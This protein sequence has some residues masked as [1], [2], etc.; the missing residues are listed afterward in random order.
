M[1]GLIENYLASIP[2]GIDGY[3]ECMHKGEPLGVWLAGSPLAGLSERVPAPVAELLREPTNLP[4]W[5][6]EVHATVIY[7]AMREVHFVTDAAFLQHAENVNRGVLET[8]LNRFLFWVASPRAILRGG[9][10]RWGSLHK[11]STIEIRKLLEDSARLTLRFPPNLLPE[12]IALG[13]GTGFKVA[14]EASGAH[15]V[16]ITMRSFDST[17]ATFESHWR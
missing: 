17:H 8:P 9:S 5:V 14:L 6:P 12:I 4:V 11:G 13:N 15:D 1:T 2:G 7:L 10:V 16:H 3:P